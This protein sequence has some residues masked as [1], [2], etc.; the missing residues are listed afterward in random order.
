MLRPDPDSLLLRQ[1][2][3][4][5]AVAALVGGSLLAEPAPALGHAVAALGGL[6]VVARLL[7][8]VLLV[9]Q[10]AVDGFRT[11]RAEGRVEDA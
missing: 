3:F 5:L 4:W 8:G 9:L 1:E 10:T 6:Y 7:V 11:G 2:A